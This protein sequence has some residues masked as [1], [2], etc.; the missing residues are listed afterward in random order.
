MTEL[1]MRYNQHPYSGTGPSGTKADGTKEDEDIGFN[2]PGGIF[3]LPLDVD[4]CNTDNFRADFNNL[5]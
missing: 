1:G 3:Q 2:I 4:K 5:Q